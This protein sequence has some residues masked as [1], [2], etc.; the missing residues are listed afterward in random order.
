MKKTIL[1]DV[2]KCTGCMMCTMACSLAKTDTFNPARARIGIVNWEN[3]GLI[4]PVLCQHCEEPVCV[5]CCPVDAMSKTET[6]GLVEINRE[7]CINCKIC[8]Q[9]CPFGGPSLASVTGEVVLC[10]HCGGNP[11]CVD[12]CPTDALKY[13][14]A[15]S[16]ITLRRHDAM[17][18]IRKSI[19]AL[20][21]A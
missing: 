7:T 18:E 5:V 6:T 9:V 2:E 3:K 14:V 16:S 1:I 17:G 11:A 13:V 12:V 10:D 20:G 4:V 8:R 21:G 15:D 19:V